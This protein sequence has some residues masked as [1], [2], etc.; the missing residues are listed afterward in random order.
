MKI[1]WA[2]WRMK[3]VQDTLQP[4]R[5]ECIFC[6]AAKA[7]E[8]E[9]YYVVYRSKH[10]Y[11]ILN[12]YP[13]NTGHVMVVPYKHV[14]CI[15]ALEDSELL[16]LSKTI[17]VAIRALREAFRP[18]GFNVGANIGRDAGAGIEDHFHVHIVPRWRGDTNFMP[19]VSETKVLPQLLDDTYRILKKAFSNITKATGT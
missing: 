17:T 3:Y 1:L 2:P 18:D 7:E 11:A 16:D 8:D 9:K 19:I 13:Y 15:T 10:S 14:A 12:K 6:V 5:D 4:R